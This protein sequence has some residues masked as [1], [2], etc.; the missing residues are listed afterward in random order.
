MPPSPPCFNKINRI[1]P[2]ANYK[3]LHLFR[4]AMTQGHI[5]RV[6]SERPHRTIQRTWLVRGLSGRR[7]LYDLP[8]TTKGIHFCTSC[9]RGVSNR[10]SCQWRCTGLH[11]TPGF[12][13]KAS[14][15][16]KLYSCRFNGGPG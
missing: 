5:L 1:L 4:G 3:N 7:G 12:L 13:F 15:Q 16:R 6:P 11:K 2:V 9:A 14:M 8:G 10:N